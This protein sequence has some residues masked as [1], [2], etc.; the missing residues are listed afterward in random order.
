MQNLISNAIK[1]RKKDTPSIIKIASKD[2]GTHY[3]LSIS[4]NGIGIAPKYQQ[5]IFSIFKK[6]HNGTD[7]QGNGIGLATCQKIVHQHKGKIW[8][9]SKEGEGATFYFTIQK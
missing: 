9:D 5:E 4:D 1:F 7:Y 2:I 3:Q 8:V 6:L